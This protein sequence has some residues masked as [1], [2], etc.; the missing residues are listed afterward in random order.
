MVSDDNAAQRGTSRTYWF[1]SEWPRSKP[2]AAASPS[3]SCAISDPSRSMEPSE[4]GDPAP[5]RTGLSIT[6]GRDGGGERALGRRGHDIVG[7]YRRLGNHTWQRLGAHRLTTRGPANSAAAR[8]RAFAALPSH[9]PTVI[10][11][12]HSRIWVAV[13]R[14]RRRAGGHERVQGCR[15]NDPEAAPPSCGGDRPGR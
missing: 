1:V 5:L 13:A 12:A 6:G 8:T 15:G 4:M 11:E 2:S 14:P 3:E 10:T 7:R 9:V